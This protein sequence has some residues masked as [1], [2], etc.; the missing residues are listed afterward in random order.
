MK[1]L[2]RARLLVF[3]SALIPSFF[4]PLRSYLFPET[5][6][7]ADDQAPNEVYIHIR[8]GRQQEAASRI[9]QKLMQGWL[10]G[11]AHHH[12]FLWP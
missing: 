12:G 1:C 6:I 5:I 8:S 2:F 4:A 11:T 3:A 10:P 7:V 9:R